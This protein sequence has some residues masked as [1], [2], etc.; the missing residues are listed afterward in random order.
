MAFRV[1]TALAVWFLLRKNRTGRAGR[2]GGRCARRRVG[3]L[4]GG[5]QVGLAGYQRLLDTALEGTWFS[6][7]A[8]LRAG[9]IELFLGVLPL[10]YGTCCCRRSPPR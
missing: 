5:R 4:A 2:R 8:D 3:R 7:P 1:L 10:P 9:G 6:K